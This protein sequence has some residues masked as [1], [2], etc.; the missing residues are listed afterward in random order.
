MVSFFAP[1]HTPL[2][3]LPPSLPLHRQVL[4]NAKGVV[5]VVLSLLYFRNPINFY[6]IFGYA[7]T[8]CGVVLYSQ[9]RRRWAPLP[10][11]VLRRRGVL[12]CRPWCGMSCS[13][14]ASS[15]PVLPPVS[16]D[17]SAHQVA[18][19]KAS[20]CC[21]V[22]AHS[23]PVPPA[24]PPPP[25][26]H[27]HT[28][29][30]AQAKKAAKKAQ[31]LQKMASGDPSVVPEAELLLATQ[32]EAGSSGKGEQGAPDTAALLRAAEKLGTK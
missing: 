29:P 24:A 21:A 14:H 31:L 20:L 11:V 32:Q 26:F 17:A 19:R 12:F 7:V 8:V 28:H 23:C 3:C 18:A 16:L 27:T 4:G 2:M 22:H 10:I 30:L 13:A 25:P 1:S 6:S 5:A 15:R 9:V